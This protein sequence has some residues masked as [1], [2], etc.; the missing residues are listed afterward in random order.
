MVR[1]TQL[2]VSIVIP[3]YNQA[4]FVA[5][6]IESGLGQRAVAVEVIVVNDG[7]TDG[8]AAVIDRFAARVQVLTQ[9]NRGLAAAR[10][11]GL[12][13]ATGEVV[14][15]L[16]ADDRLHPDAARV[17]GQTFTRHPGAAMVFGRCRLVDVDGA[18]LPTPLPSVSADFYAALLRH[19]YIWMPAMAAFQRQVFAHIGAFDP[20]VNGSADYDLYLRIARQCPIAAHDSVVADYRQH[21]GSMSRHPVPMLKTTLRVMRAQRARIAG[22]TRLRAAWHEGMRHWRWFYGEPLVEQFRTAMHSARYRD[23]VHAAI[24]LLRWYPAG[25]AAHVDR[26]LRLV[27]RSVRRR[28]LPPSRALPIR[29]AAG[30][31]TE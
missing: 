18:P 28:S 1:M 4:H 14:I 23:A 3:C 15:F 21:A 8:S 6:A 17:A 22:D 20:R 29:Q 9:R 10:N 16:D 12:D 24:R 31:E 25:A 26:K 19:N 7:S 2:R 5:E 11:A 30:A 13:A 27:A